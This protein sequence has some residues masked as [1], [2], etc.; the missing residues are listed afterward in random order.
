MSLTGLL[1]DAGGF[2]K[3]IPFFVFGALFNHFKGGGYYIAGGPQEITR[4]IIS[5][6]ESTGGRCFASLSFIL[7]VDFQDYGKM[8]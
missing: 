1:G 8:W 7:C 3:D 6:I 2:R 5:T 4:A